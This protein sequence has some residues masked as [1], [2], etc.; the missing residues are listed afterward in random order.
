MEINHQEIIKKLSSL[1]EKGYI[2]VAFS[3]INYDGYYSLDLLM[4]HSLWQEYEFHNQFDQ[5]LKDLENLLPKEL[6]YTLE[7]PTKEMYL[8]HRKEDAPVQEHLVFDLI[9]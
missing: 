3:I 2:K 9:K 1:K 6:D 8:T 4:I 7:I 5:C